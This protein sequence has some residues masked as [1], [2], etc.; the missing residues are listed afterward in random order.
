MIQGEPRGAEAAQEELKRLGEQGEAAVQRLYPMLASYLDDLRTHLEANLLQA[1]FQLA[2]QLY[3]QQFTALSDGERQ[4]LRQRLHR[5]CQRCGSL[6]TIEQLLQLAL[7]LE[8]HDPSPRPL[9]PHSGELEV[10][11]A[12]EPSLPPGSIALELETPPLL[13]S[14]DPWLF[15]GHPPEES[16]DDPEDEEDDQ[17][18]VDIDPIEGRQEE[19]FGAEENQRQELD[20]RS[21][22]A[23]ALLQDLM[24][25]GEL[26]ASPTLEAEGF[27]VA[28]PMPRHPLALHR[29]LQGWDK[30]LTRRLRNLSHA[31]NVELL[32]FG[33]TRS[34]MPM[35]LLDAVLEGQADAQSAPPN[36]L[37]LSLPLGA[38]GME[39][40]FNLHAVL[41]RS[42]DFEYLRPPLRRRRAQIRQLGK[43]LL[44]MARR[45]HHWQ[46]RL[47]IRQAEQQ[48]LEDNDQP[49][50]PEP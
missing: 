18:E 27:T 43:N 36:L 29:W 28:F 40:D 13:G 11:E 14:F 47:A 9:E 26:Q 22:E 44:K 30:A 33:L 1:V 50:N 5:L 38:N 19:E 35:A 46:Q 49:L 34:L 16:G 45:Q 15:S 8:Q 3:P 4:A 42:S 41:L 20:I 32:R 39:R 31:V 25:G 24:G 7:R 6:L 23:F 12:E 2:T 48:W 21:R 10:V 17:D 37:S